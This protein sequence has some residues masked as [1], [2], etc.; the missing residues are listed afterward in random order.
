MSVI[1]PL[2]DTLLHEVLGKRM[3]PP[4]RRALNEAATP[5]VRVDSP[6]AV[7]SD[8]RLNQGQAGA[9]RSHADAAS[10]AGSAAPPR[11]GPSATAQ[12]PPPNAEVYP[13]LSGTARLISSLLEQFPQPPSTIRSSTPLVAAPQE[14]VT[15]E[16]L[17]GRLQGRISESGLFYESHLSR[18]YHGEL[19]T[20]QLEREPQ[21]QSGRQAGLAVEES[22]QPLVRHQLEMIASPVLRW[23]GDVW[24]GIFMALTIQLSENAA[25]H[26]QKDDAD[27]KDAQEEE[28][29]WQSSITLRLAEFGELHV[30]LSLSSEEQLGLVL[31]SSSD[32]LV[33]QLEARRGALLERLA[34]CGFVSTQLRLIKTPGVA[35]DE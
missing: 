5:V 9:A 16:L 15:P 27:Q 23:E 1:T 19:S 29:G 18:W 32:V 4:A 24:S 14:S 31:Q 25:G 30:R 3:D 11:S 35:S 34:D 13:R 8:S 21:M 22:L 7:R 20:R 33:E 2:L 10:R 26:P 28:K 17:A 6:L 12:G